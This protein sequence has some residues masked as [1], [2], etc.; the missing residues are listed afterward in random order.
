MDMMRP[1]SLV[2]PPLQADGLAFSVVNRHLQLTFNDNSINET[3]FVVQRNSNGTTWVDAGTIPAPLD[4]PNVHEVRTFTD[5]A[6]YNPNTVYE[7]RVVAKN[8]AGYGAEFPSMTAQ[9]VSATMPTGV[10]PAA[11]SALQAAVQAGPQVALSF[12]DNATD[13][14]GFTVQRS[15]DAGVTW[16]VVASLP[17]NT[18]AN[19]AV[20]GTVTWTDTTV[21]AGVTYQY[22]VA[23]D[24]G[25]ASSTW[26]NTATAAVPAMPAAPGG[27]TVTLQTGPQGYLHWM[28]NATNADALIVQRALHGTSSFI[29]VATPAASATS[30]TDVTVAAG[31]SYDYRVAANNTIVGRSAWSNTATLDV[32]GLA[33][34]PQNVQA[35]VARTAAGPDTVTLTWVDSAA[36]ATSFTVQR[37]TNAAFT[38]NLT[39]YTVPGVT[40]LTNPVNHGQTY[41]YRVQAVNILGTSGWSASASVGTVPAVPTNFRMTA[42]TRTSIT[43]AW[44]DISGNETGYQ[45]QRH[46]AGL[47]TWSNVTTTGANA[48]SR[49]DG[50]RVRN[51]TY[52]YRIRGRNAVG[53]SP[54][55]AA[56]KVSTAP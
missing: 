14:S 27:L 41:Y 39:S 4:Q 23:A 42:R 32:P 36:T 51:T 21:A 52:Y 13:E 43:L 7:Y 31:F 20:T 46:R 15:D 50:G 48:T 22:R 40:T 16:G 24:K 53:D 30:W 11:P 34:V 45:I 54:W 28:N 3:S 8:T 10:P 18:V 25:A 6:T 19:P 26:S 49:T 44:G 5:P 38:S 17:A 9:S 56:L 33:A 1:Q 29:D 55:T 37:A 2:L 35:S 47:T 12:T